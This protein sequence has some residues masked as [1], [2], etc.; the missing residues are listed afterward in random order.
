MSRDTDSSD[1]YDL[2][3]EDR[4]VFNGSCDKFV[5][6]FLL[7][8][9]FDKYARPIKKGAAKRKRPSKM[10]EEELYTH[11]ERPQGCK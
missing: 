9:G 8:N 3:D 4:P 10:M 6:A 7:A 1:F 5:T 2:I 11:W